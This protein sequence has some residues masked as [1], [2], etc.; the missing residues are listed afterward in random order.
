[1]IHSKTWQNQ[2][3]LSSALSN[4]NKLI[5]GDNGLTLNE[6]SASM[7]RALNKN[8]PATVYVFNP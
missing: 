7:N 5:F 1:M 4:I 2:N 3:H 6:N 8:E